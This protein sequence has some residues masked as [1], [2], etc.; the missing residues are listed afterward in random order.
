MIF[1]IADMH[2]GHENVLRFDDRPFSEIGQMDET[3]VQNWN[4]RVTDDDTVY[5]LGDAFWKNEEN[6]VKILPQL[7]GHKHLIQGNH[8]RVKGK[9]RLYW[10][11]IA[12]YAEINDENRLVILSHYPMLF[13]KSQ[14]H[15]AAMLY[16]HVHNSREWQ[17]VEKWKREQWAL[18][19]PCRLI[20]VGCMLDYMHYT[21]RTLTELLAA[22][23]MPDMDLFARIEES[24]AQFESAKTQVYEL[25]KQAV[26]K[27]LAGQL[28]DEAQ[29]DRLLDRVID[30][31]DDAR[32]RELSK[33]LCRHI[34][35]HYPKLIGGFP[36]MFRALFEEKE[37]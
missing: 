20:N 8:D 32:F 36:S 37:T 33:Q 22:E 7:N 1:Y 2:F 28:T 30:F 15:G 11:S 5:V 24:A 18:G 14:H 29:I 9:L 27:V 26:D 4:A 19:I 25:C 21:P 17:L 16:G 12:Q 34:Y 13:Y 3:L 6:S 23:S 10:E 31:G 35:Y